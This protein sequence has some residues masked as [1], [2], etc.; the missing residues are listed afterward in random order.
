MCVR[1]AAFAFKEIGG[2]VAVETLIKGMGDEN[3]GVRSSAALSLGEI[4]SSAAVGSL[5]NA[6]LDKDSNVRSCAAQALGEIGGAGAIKSLIEATGHEDR[7]TRGGAAYALGRIGNAAAIESLIKAL[8]DKDSGV[9][10]GAAYA[11][12][13]IGHEAALDSLIKAMEDKDWDVRSGAAYALGKIGHEPAIYG[14]IQALADKDFGVRERAAEALGEIGSAVAVDSLIKAMGDINYHVRSG[15]AYALGEIGG[16][17]SVE[18]LVGAMGDTDGQVRC[19]AIEALGEIGGAAAIDSLIKAMEDKYTYVRSAGARALGKFEA[20]PAVE[21]LITALGD[22]ELFVHLSAADAL[23]RTGRAMDLQVLLES[24]L[25]NDSPFLLDRVA[26]IQ[27]RV[28]IYNYE[29]SLKLDVQSTAKGGMR[30]LATKTAEKTISVKGA[31]RLLHLSDLH[32][33]AKGNSADWNIDADTWAR[34]LLEDLDRLHAAPVNAMVVSGDIAN[35]CRVDEYQAA[36]A[37]VGMVRVGLKLASDALIIVPGNHDVDFAKSKAGFEWKDADAV[38]VDENR[39]T[40][41]WDE[42]KLEGYRT[43]TLTAYGER[44]AHFSAF[45]Q[46]A[47]GRPFLSGDYGSQV[48]VHPFPENRVVIVGLNSAWDV[49]HKRND[50][51]S[52]HPGALNTALNNVTADHEGYLKICVWHH[53]Y[54]QQT[55]AGSRMRQS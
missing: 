25:S 28:R 24:A 22:K 55:T 33:G 48:S 20:D 45:Y 27:E 34:N 29:H 47:T 42:G 18:R 31:F 2:N 1:E 46:E 17:A 7:E 3:S 4:G 43:P 16:D 10:S 15:A 37:F 40:K 9:R 50:W 52:I 26:A 8:E 54:P 13:A 21:C 49:N 30:T 41:I 12:G 44:F 6:M 53:P 14:L 39:C 51:V 32:F 19:S 36:A 35:R 5:I 23:G 38:D 11:L